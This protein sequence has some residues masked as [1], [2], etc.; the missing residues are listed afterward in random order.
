MQTYLIHDLSLLHRRARSR[1]IVIIMD[2]NLYIILCIYIYKS[3][4]I[5]I[6]SV[7]I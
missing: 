6:D 7:I 4:V 2:I 3:T 5:Y 1:S